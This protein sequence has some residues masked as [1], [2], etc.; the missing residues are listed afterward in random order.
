VQQLLYFPAP[1]SLFSPYS[2]LM[3]DSAAFFVMVTTTSGVFEYFID[4]Y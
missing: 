4:K 1:F 3:A 2:L